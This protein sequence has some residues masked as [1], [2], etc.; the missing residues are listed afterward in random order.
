MLAVCLSATSPQ[1]ET[2]DGI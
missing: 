1:H 2:C